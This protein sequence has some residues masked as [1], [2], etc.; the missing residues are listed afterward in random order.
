M[1]ERGILIQRL[2][3][4]NKNGHNPF[5][6]GCTGNGGFSEEGYNYITKLCEFDYMGASEFEWGQFQKLLI[7]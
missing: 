7:K 4:P 2:R 3:K 5:A 6:F 1:L